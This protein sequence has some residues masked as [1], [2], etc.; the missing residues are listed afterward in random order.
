MLYLSLDDGIAIYIVTG[1]ML[2]LL[3]VTGLILIQKYGMFTLMAKIGGTIITHDDWEDINDNAKEVDTIIKAIY[4][5]RKRF[6]LAIFYKTLGLVL[7][8]VEVWFACYLL[9]SPIGLLEAMMLKSLT[10]TIT[11]IAFINPE[12]LWDP[13]RCI[14]YDRRINGH[15]TRYGTCDF[16]SDSFQRT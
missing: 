1:F 4:Q 15:R 16:F 7:Q 3:C 8:T 12:W 9:G 5:D 13:G 10:Q 14:Y 11:D 6:L 2:L